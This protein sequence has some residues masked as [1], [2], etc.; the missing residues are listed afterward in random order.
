MKSNYYIAGNGQ[1]V[2]MSTEKKM[3][4]KMSESFLGNQHNIHTNM[5]Q[6]QHTH[7][8]RNGRQIPLFFSYFRNLKVSMCKPKSATIMGLITGVQGQ[9]KLEYKSL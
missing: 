4:P 7:T 2:S 1:V 5:W 6:R 3:P 8:Q 9:F